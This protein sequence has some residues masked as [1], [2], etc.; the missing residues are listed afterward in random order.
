MVCV[1]CFPCSHRDIRIATVHQFSFCQFAE[2]LHSID[3]DVANLY[4]GSLECQ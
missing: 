3:F 4:L 2:K 1:F